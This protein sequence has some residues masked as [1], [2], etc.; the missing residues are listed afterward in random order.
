MHE[1]PEL[2][3]CVTTDTCGNTIWT[4]LGTADLALCK[5]EIISLEKLYIKNSERN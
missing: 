4:S 5:G 3:M 1:S 2:R